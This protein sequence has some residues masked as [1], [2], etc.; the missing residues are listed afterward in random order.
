MLFKQLF[1]GFGYKVV[2]MPRCV[3]GYPVLPVVFC[4]GTFRVGQ[5][6]NEYSVRCKL[7][8]GIFKG[9]VDGVNMLKGVPQYNSIKL[10][11][12]VSCIAQ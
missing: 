1:K 8:S 5:G 11:L 7:L 9:F 12:S 10:Y 4:I 3:P 2:E 6:N